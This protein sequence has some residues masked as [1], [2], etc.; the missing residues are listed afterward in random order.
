MAQNNPTLAEV[1]LS[2]PAASRVLHERGLDYCCG[3][4]RRLDDACREAGLDPDAVLEEIRSQP[5]RQSVAWT[6]RPLDEL[7]DHI[8]TNY[9]A[10]LR[11]ELPDLVALATKVE[12]RHHD[13]P[14]CPHGL[15]AHL[16]AVHESVLDHLGKEEMMLFPL[17]VNGHGP[18]AGA[19]VQVME[20]EH[21]DHAANLQR[22]R[23]LTQDL[24]PPPEACT[25]WR[26]L[27]LRL[28]ELEAELMEHIHLENNVLFPRALRE[29]E[30]R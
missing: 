30:V 24:T 12:E 4:H 19:P 11:R 29:E 14:T 25:S 18:Q 10:A 5:A 2:T 27:Y 16:R 7:V 15:A 8:V 26:A 6:D 28:G 23:T 1:A 9:H 20:H 21:R 13:K 17:I 22:I 3:G